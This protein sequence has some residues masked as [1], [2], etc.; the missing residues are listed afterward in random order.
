VPRKH[1]RIWISTYHLSSFK[2]IKISQKVCLTCNLFAEAILQF[3][4]GRLAA[5]LLKLTNISNFYPRP[6]T[7]MLESSLVDK[8]LAQRTYRKK[9]F[10]QLAWISKIDCNFPFVSYFMLVFISF[11]NI[12]IPNY[13]THHN[14]LI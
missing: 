9:A 13:N 14:Q 2:I 4:P 8:S 3:D 5:S 12:K 6:K 10:P 1:L 11:S 7:L